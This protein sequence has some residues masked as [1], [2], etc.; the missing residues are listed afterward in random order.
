M[1]KL[2]YYTSKIAGI[3]KDEKDRYKAHEKAAPV[4]KAMGADQEVL[5]DVFR[6][7]LSDPEFINKDRHYPTVAFE[8]YQDANVGISGNC[9]MPVPDRR[10]DLTI[11]SI[12]HHGKLLLTTVAAFGP[13]YHSTLFKKGFTFDK[14]TM[15]AKLELEKHYQFHKGSLEFID[16]NQPHVVFFPKSPSITFAMWAYK[17]VNNAVQTFK[18]NALINKFKEPIRKMLKLLWLTNK[19]GINVVEY[20]DFYPKNGEFKVLK[21]R[22]KF[23]SGDNKNFLTNVFYVLQTAE[24]NDFAFLH[25]L[26]EKHTANTHLHQLIDKLEKN[27]EIRDEFYEFHKNVPF[28]NFTKEE[29]FAAANHSQ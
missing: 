25:Q 26:K 23:E 14:N 7:S 15:D 29:I 20:L 3:F 4:L 27:I 24:F 1:E 2:N 19:A 22:I 16:A 11:V 18:N 28:V 6:Q 5:F 21:E 10:E 13:G 17:D 8:I 12:H 9:F